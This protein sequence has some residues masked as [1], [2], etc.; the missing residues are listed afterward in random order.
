MNSFIIYILIGY[1]W[2]DY[3]V[4]S[5]DATSVSQ[6]FGPQCGNYWGS[7]IRLPYKNKIPQV[8]WAQHSSWL[9]YEK[10]I[11]WFSPLFIFCF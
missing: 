10:W 4:P 9:M 11:I 6:T 5:E 8:R 1:F 2:R 3:S 7:F